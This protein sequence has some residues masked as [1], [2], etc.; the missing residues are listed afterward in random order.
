MKIS[1]HSV[2]FTIKVDGKLVNI[3]FYTDLILF[4][5]VYVQISMWIF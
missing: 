2:L 1:P 5:Y 4:N 3:L